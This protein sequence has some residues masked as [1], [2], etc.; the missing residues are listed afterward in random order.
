MEAAWKWQRDAFAAGAPAC[1]PASATMDCVKVLGG[2]LVG[3]FA[4]KWPERTVDLL[5]EA[6]RQVLERALQAYEAGEL[7]AWAEKGQGRETFQAEV[8]LPAGPWMAPLCQLLARK[9]SDKWTVHHA[10]ALRL[11][12]LGG[13]PSRKGR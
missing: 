9:P 11:S 4:Q 2:E 8:G 10:N 3:P 12:I 7:R 13:F 1:G 5:Q 6:P